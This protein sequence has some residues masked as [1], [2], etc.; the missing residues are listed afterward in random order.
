MTENQP[1][2]VSKTKSMPKHSIMTEDTRQSL[3]IIHRSKIMLKKNILNFV[4]DRFLSP[5]KSQL[6]ARRYHS[7]TFV[8][9][10]EIH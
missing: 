5:F 4:H 2:A 7:V 9:R 6:D 1:I 8:L 3:S 10:I